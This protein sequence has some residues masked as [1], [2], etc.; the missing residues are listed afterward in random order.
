MSSIVMMWTNDHSDMDATPRNSLWTLELLILIICC[1]YYFLPL[2]LSTFVFFDHACL[3]LLCK[4][5]F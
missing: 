1:T 5:H 4:D 2:M 3:F